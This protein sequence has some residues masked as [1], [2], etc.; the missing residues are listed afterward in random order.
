MKAPVD[1]NDIRIRHIVEAIRDI[2]EFTSGLTYKEFREDARS[3][4]ACLY[5]LSVI[6]EAVSRLDSHITDQLE[7]PWHRVKAFRN[8]ILHEYH[9]VDEKLVWETI[10]SVLPEFKRIMQ[11]LLKK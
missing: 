1:R 8:F 5:R 4:Y 6:G 7:Y 3:Y 9:K 2:E 11:L 10:H